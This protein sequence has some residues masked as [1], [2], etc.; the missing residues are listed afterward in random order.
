[1]SASMIEEEYCTSPKTK[2]VCTIGLE[3]CELDR[4]EWHWAMVEHARRLN[5]EKGHEMV[6]LLDMKGSEIHK[7]DLG[8]ESSTKI[9]VLLMFVV[10]IVCVGI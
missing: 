6:I 1:M 7:G 8:S 5:E 2:L 3:M 4:L 10:S 9:E